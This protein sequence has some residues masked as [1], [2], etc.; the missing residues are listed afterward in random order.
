MPRWKVAATKP[1]R[2][3]TTP[4]PSATSAVPRSAPRAM[5]RSSRRSR[6][7]RD[8]LV[9]PAGTT[10]T[11][12]GSPRRRRNAASSRPW[13]GAR[14]ASVTTMYRRARARRRRST[15]MRG[16]RPRPIRMWCDS[17]TD[18]RRRTATRI[19]GPG[20]VTAGVGDGGR[21]RLQIVGHELPMRGV[22]ELALDQPLGR[23]DGEIGDLPAELLDRLLLLVLDLALALLDQV[24][25][26]L[27]RLRQELGA[28]R[29]ALLPP[30]L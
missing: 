30:L 10:T 12:V 21:Q 22:V 23:A 1:V 18:R 13:R 4:P 26:L 16:P 11:S 5:S 25:R 3:P 28:E 29:L 2:S 14:F 19:T 20:S 17:S 15:E 6:T 24:L 9:S 27:A 8:L 7:L